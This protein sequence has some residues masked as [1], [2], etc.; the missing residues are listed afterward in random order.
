METNKNENTTVQN[1]WDATK[2]VLWGKYI[3]LQTF[4]KK[5][6]RSQIHKLTLHLKELDK[7]QQIKPKPRGRRELIQVRAEINEIETKRTVEQIDETRSCF[8]ERINKNQ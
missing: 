4:L 7:E 1:F 5:Q 6:E 8:F 2:A 3:A